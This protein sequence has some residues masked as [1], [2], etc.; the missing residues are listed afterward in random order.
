MATPQ[1]D[2]MGVGIPPELAGRPPRLAG[3]VA[4]VTGAGSVG[5][6]WGNGRATAA[7]FAREGAEIFAVDRNVE[8]V[9]ATRAAILERGGICETH[10]ADVT[11]AEAVGRLAEACLERYGRIDVLHNNVGIAHV[12]GPLDTAEADW[13][14]LMAANIKS[15]F[16]TCKAVIP[17]MLAQ[18]EREGRGG[19]IV[20]MGA[21]AGIRWTGVPLLAYAASKGAIVPFSKQIAL[22]YA[23]QRIRCN[24]VT[25]GFLETPMI[26]VLRDAYGAADF[27]EMMRKRDRQIP[28]GKMGTGWDVAHAALFLA[29]D[30]A[31]FIT[32]QSL[33]VDGG[34]TSQT[35]LDSN[36]N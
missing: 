21:I 23:R 9:E 6:G 33:V 8:A 3:K 20:N 16:L 4:I 24:A 5:D 17:I 31:D 34:V 2:A 12:G 7:V 32:G 22:Q 30:E 14:R 18:F 15:M 27:D 10:V 28:R 11:D 35:W 26:T 36:D 19:A 1:Q 25:A 29:S 13:D